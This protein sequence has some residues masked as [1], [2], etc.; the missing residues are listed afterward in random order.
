M[1][2]LYTHQQAGRAS[3]PVR[4]LKGFQRVTLKPGETR[5][6]SFTLDEKSVQ[7]WNAAERDWVIDPG[8]FDL[9]V[10]S[11]SNAQNHGQFTVSGTARAG[12]GFAPR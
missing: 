2:Q 12:S 11:S 5:T 3:R 4:E 8:M 7:Y 9:W 10:G 1:V 6:V